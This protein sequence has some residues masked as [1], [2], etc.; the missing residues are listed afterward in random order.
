MSSHLPGPVF[1]HEGNVSVR[2]YAQRRYVSGSSG[3]G[4]LE[5]RGGGREEGREKPRRRLG[6]G[7]RG[8]GG[9]ED[10]EPARP[11]ARSPRAARR[12]SH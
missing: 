6:V 11:P 4:E 2:M 9:G 3:S 7:G 10:G 12:H 8:G 1:S 5:Q